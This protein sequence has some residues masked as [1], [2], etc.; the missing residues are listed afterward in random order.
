ME[1]RTQQ[2]GGIVAGVE[3]HEPR[4]RGDPDDPGAVK[5]EFL[6]AGRLF[7]FGG[8][9]EIAED[10]SGGI[11]LVE[12]VHQGQDIDRTAELDD[13]PDQGVVVTQHGEQFIFARPGIEA[14][15]FGSDRDIDMPVETHQ[16]EIG[17]V[18]SD[19]VGQRIGADGRRAFGVERL[20]SVVPDQPDRPVGIGGYRADISIQRGF[21]ALQPVVESEQA[22]IGTDVESAVTA[23]DD[24][25]VEPV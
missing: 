25:S 23:G 22:L 17:S 13:I 21:E 9:L 15:Q 11:T 8:E 18:G 5:E 14:E 19:L 20:D 1:I 10:V 3:Q 24:L 7:V 6:G 12:S 16:R 4:L 2:P